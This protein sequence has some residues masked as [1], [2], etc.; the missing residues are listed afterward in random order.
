MRNDTGPSEA[1]HRYAAAY[2]AHYE[3]RELG[4]ALGLYKE[5]IAAHPS[6][7]EAGYS[8]SQILNIVKVVVPEQEI[9]EAQANLASAHFEHG[10]Q[11]Q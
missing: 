8:R 2:V 10:E 7:L 5:I 6:T 1:S 4:A 11:P 3:A 9:F